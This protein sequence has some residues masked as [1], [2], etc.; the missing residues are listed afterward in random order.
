[1]D[2]EFKTLINR[3]KEI[4]SIGYVKGINNNTNSCGLTFEHLINKK[5][6]DMFFPDYN[7]IE[8]KCTTRFSRYDVNLFSL[9]FDGPHTFESSYL[10]NTYGIV[11]NKTNSKELIINLYANEKIIVNKE[12]YFKLLIDYKKNKICID[13]YDIHHNFIERSG[14]IYF[15]KLKKRIELKLE[16]LAMIYASKKNIDGNYFF[17]YYKII[18]YKLSNFKQFLYLLQLGNINVTLMLRHSKSEK[19]Y[20]KQKNKN[21][22]FKIKKEYVSKLF[23]QIYIYEN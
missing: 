2:I 7:G 18:C 19:S 13:I 21:M 4:N 12:Y 20:G 8:I 11:N 16:N 15:D 9:S 6:D 3:F 14:I 17:R 10:L 1:M 5:E 23:K 22:V